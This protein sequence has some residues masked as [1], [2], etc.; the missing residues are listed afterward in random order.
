MNTIIYIRTSTE[1]QNPE[2]QLS[3]CESIRPK[4][5]DML[6]FVNY[7]LLQD[8][9]SAWNDNKEREGFTEL[10]KLIKAK[11]VSNLIVW[12]MDRIYRNRKRLIEF[13]QLCKAYKVNVYSFRQQFLNSINDIP[14][15]WGEM[16]HSFM[17][18]IIGWMGEDESNKKSERVKNAV[19]KDKGTT[20]SY[21]GNKWGRKDL[22]ELR[23]EQ[24]NVLRNQGNTI[25][26][27]AKELK[28][29]V[30]VVHKYITENNKEIKTE[31]TLSLISQ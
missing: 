9:Q 6:T 15:P 30:G 26:F 8:K 14:E 5:N 18:Q 29:S 4:S 20:L 28:I 12:D 1:K 11:K 3:D 7:Q 17:L 21:K 13:M 23:Q 19:R 2:N 25:R 27:I 24:I 10:L 16:M 31:N 22:S